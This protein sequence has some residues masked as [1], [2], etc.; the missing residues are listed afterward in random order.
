M[1]NARKAVCFFLGVVA[2]TLV[3]FALMFI[4]RMR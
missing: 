4:S 1:T 3:S 2:A